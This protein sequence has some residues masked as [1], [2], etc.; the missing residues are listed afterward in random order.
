MSSFQRMALQ[1]RTGWLSQIAFF[2]NILLKLFPV[3]KMDVEIC[4]VRNHLELNQ[5]KIKTLSYHTHIK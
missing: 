1:K 4:R 3:V 2:I 5:K